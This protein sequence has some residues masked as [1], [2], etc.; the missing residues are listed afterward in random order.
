MKTNWLIYIRVS[1]DDQA[2]KGVSL[3]AQLTACRAFC[4]ARGWAIAEEITDPGASAATLK[5]PGMQRVLELLRSGSIAGVI[6]WRLDR[7]T[8][9]IRDLLDLLEIAGQRAGIVSVTESLDT[10]TPMGRFVVHLLGSIAQWERETIGARTTSAMQHARSL[11]F[12][13]GGRAPPAGTV[14]VADGHRRRLARGPDADAVARAWP[15]ILAGGSLRDVAGALQ[16]A[17]I[18]GTWTPAAVRNLLLSPQVVPVLVDAST[19]AAVR[20]RLSRRASP[21]SRGQQQHPRKTQRES[22][23]RG[24]LRCTS[25]DAAMV[26]VTATGHG[27][28]YHYFR[29]TARVKGL[30][31]QKDIRCEPVELVALQAVADA[32]QPG[33]SYQATMRQELQEALGKVDAARSESVG[34]RSERD[35]LGARISDLTLRQQIGTTSWN[36]AMGALGAEIDRIDRRL[37]ELAGTL[38]AAEIDKGSLD[39]VMAEIADQAHKLPVLPVEKQTRI[40]QALVARIRLGD[41]QVELDLYAPG[42]QK[43]NGP[44]DTPPGSLKASFWLPGRDSNPRPSD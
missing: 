28:R 32:C 5:R 1:S 2:E 4:V 13:T 42:A 21:S 3:D 24:L 38:A 30:C 17:G 19:Q 14:V 22:P 37:A 41:Q 8:R 16:A 23:L 18:P 31:Q 43:D 29:C 34:L 7:L 15:Q 36:I 9:S 20:S 6:A 11:G 27:G 12:Y 35:Q 40:L 39:V 26:Q 25:C 33:G 44:G 10:T